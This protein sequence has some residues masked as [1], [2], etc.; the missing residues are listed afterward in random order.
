MPLFDPFLDPFWDRSGRVRTHF[1][2]VV[3]AVIWAYSLK[4]HDLVILGHF[5]P[6]WACLGQWCFDPILAI[7]CTL[8]VPTFLTY[9]GACA[10]AR[11]RTRFGAIWTLF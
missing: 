3:T 9:F 10:R 4:A 1:T 2:Q 8:L 11:M 6:F 5:S 7:F